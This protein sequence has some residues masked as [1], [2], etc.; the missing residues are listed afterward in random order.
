MLEKWT[1]FTKVQDKMSIQ[2]KSMFQSATALIRRNKRA[3]TV[4]EI[5][6]V[7]AIIGMIVALGVANFGR[8]FSSSQEDIAR[9]FVN[10]ALSAPLMAYRRDMGRYPTTE[11]GLQALITAPAARADRWRGPY[12]EGGINRL[13]DP[14]GNPYQYRFPGEINP[15]RF[16]LFSIGPDTVAGTD[17]DVGNW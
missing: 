8:I 13:V 16:D 10:S 6:I 2:S 12:V 4:L 7:L 14:W 9:T 17:D 5:L 3:F 15:D 11:E 1:K